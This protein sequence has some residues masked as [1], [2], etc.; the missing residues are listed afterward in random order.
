MKFRLFSI[1]IVLAAISVLSIADDAPFPG[2][3]SDWNGYDA[4]DFE[5]GGRP[6]KVVVPKEAAPG[7]PWIWRAL[8]W[9]HEPQ[10]D[11]ALLAKGFHVVY[12]ETSDMYSSPKS[13]QEWDACYAF[14]TKEKGLSKKAA[15]EGLS[16]AGLICYNWAAAHPERVSCIYADAPVCDIRSWPSGRLTS[17]GNPAAWKD[18][19]DAFGYTEEQAFAQF[20]NPIDVLEP[21]AKAR[22]PLLHVVGDADT[23]VPVSENTAIL[24]ERYKKLGG[25]ITVI[26]KPGVAHHPHSLVDP[27][28]IVG[29]IVKHTEGFAAK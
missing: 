12:L 26:H 28:P 23:D 5:C 14:L 27:A 11:T 2:A 24:E 18:L 13:M 1:A 4:Y 25:D 8:F 17:P 19:L 6:A 7:M 20:K 9:A 22:I 29:F 16:R 3:R 10:V 15:L 21:I